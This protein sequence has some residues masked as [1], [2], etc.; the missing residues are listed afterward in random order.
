M[1]QLFSISMGSTYEWF[2]STV[3]ETGAAETEIKMTLDNLLQ[4]FRTA[5]NSMP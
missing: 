5:S 2:F 1:K 4:D 3:C